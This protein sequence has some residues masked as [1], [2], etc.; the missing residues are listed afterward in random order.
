LLRAHSAAE[1]VRQQ[2]QGYGNP[3]VSSLLGE[4]RIVAVGST[5]YWSEKWLVFPDFLLWFLKLTLGNEWGSSALRQGT[6]HPVFRWLSKFEQYSTQHRR[7]DGRL[8]SGPIVG[9]IASVLNL[10][11]ALYLIAHNDEIQG[12]LLQRLR[13]TESF[14]HAYYETLVGAAF[15]VAG[16]E[17]RS[18][19]TRATSTATPEFRARSKASGKLYSVE[20]KR[21]AGWSARTHDL[22]APDFLR[23]L[24]Q[25][26]RDKIHQAARKMLP[27]PIFCLELSIPTLLMESEWR[28]I[29]AN[30][31]LAI[32]EAEGM[33]INGQPM[34][35]AY[36]VVTNHTFLVNEDE[37]GA[38]AFGLVDAL[39]TPDYPF[40]RPME[41]EDSLDGYDR[42]R[43]IFWMM[44]AW[45]VARTVPTT[46]D[47]S[48][49]EL[50]SPDGQP[51]RTIKI[52]DMIETRDE[53]G[54]AVG[55]QIEELVS[56][57]EWVSVILRDT[58][59]DRRWLTRVPLTESETKAA[60]RYTDAVF[61]KANAS[62][63]LNKNDP[64]DLYDWLLEAHASS[65]PEQLAKLCEGDVHLRPFAD[66]PLAELRIRIAREYTKRMW[67]M[68]QQKK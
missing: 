22:A 15:A 37:S 7:S 24:R 36:V 5:I 19:E 12:L 18:A 54:N 40:G 32:R 52:G 68:K 39:R 29:A 43:D 13:S 25:Y 3:I 1:S 59:T 47:G 38:P 50:L 27:N 31:E 49:P 55:A 62:R 45:G 28:A 66:L 20:A 34:P 48:P 60:A 56:M 57:G 26:V 63:G 35:P 41:I 11:Y 61:G 23:E 44:K 65:T 53:L 17:V 6:K 51:Q 58:A 9:Y 64:F 14:M 16:F 42:H 46:F 4:Y 2:Q 33:T 8:Q 67:A 30:V 10:A 21:K